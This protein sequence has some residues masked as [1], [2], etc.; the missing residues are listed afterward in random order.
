MQDKLY[1]RSTILLG[2][3][4]I[5]DLLAILWLF[6]NR[7]YWA[8]YGFKIIVFFVL[9]IFLL[10]IIYTYID[11][12][13]DRNII[14]KMVRNG[15]IAL[16][17]INKGTFYRV[18]K[19]A[20]LKNNTLWKLEIDVFDQDMNS[21]KT[22]IIEKFSPT[23]T[24]IPSGYCF[25][26]YNPKK[27]KNILVIP[28]IIISSIQ[29]FAPLVKE[30]EDKFKPKYLNVYYNKGIVIETFKDSIKNAKD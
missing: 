18:I 11:I 30:Y 17:K 12:N 13:Q 24:S 27:P 14:K 5:I 22:E 15:D 23:Q 1:K 7:D 16:C 4:L 9:G 3:I 20:K 19:N 26:T 29:E 8:A 6:L 28:N 21:F 10:T 2:F 25:I